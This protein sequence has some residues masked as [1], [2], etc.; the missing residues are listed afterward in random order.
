MIWV[1]GDVDGKQYKE[2][3]SK[4]ILS[5]SLNVADLGTERAHKIA[6]DIEADLI[7]KILLKF[8]VV[9]WRMKY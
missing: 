5:R 4:G 1:I 3:F 6:S 7:K 2:P 8:P 9:I